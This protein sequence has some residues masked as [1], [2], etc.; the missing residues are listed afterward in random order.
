MYFVGRVKMVVWMWT[1][2]ETEKS[3]IPSVLF[4]FFIFSV[5]KYGLSCVE[6]GTS[7][8]GT[9]LRRGWS[10]ASDFYTC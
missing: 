6:L 7:V 9:S 10:I 4:L 8:G 5:C 1:L 2:R 3:K